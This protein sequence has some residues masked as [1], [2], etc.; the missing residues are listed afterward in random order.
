MNPN[1]LR[2]VVE[3]DERHRRTSPGLL[4]GATKRRRAD[5]RGRSTQFLG[6]LYSYLQARK[7]P[8]GPF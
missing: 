6:L 8:T 5:A 3:E 4:D 2:G 1:P 7:V